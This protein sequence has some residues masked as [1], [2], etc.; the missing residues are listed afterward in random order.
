MRAPYIAVTVAVGCILAACGRGGPA[1]PPP[2]PAVD[3]EERVFSDDNVGIR[4]SVTL[5]IRDRDSL[6]AVWQRVT[7]TRSRP[8][9]VSEVPGLA[10]VDFQRQMLLLVAAGRMV[11]GDQIRV[12]SAGVRRERTGS[13]REENVLV[14]LYTITEGCRRINEP[15]F[16]LEI[17]RVRRH[18]GAVDFRGRRDRA[19]NC[20]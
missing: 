9:P 12:D 1:T 17:V 11:S 2:I 19:T 14:V 18:D 16:P 4:D 6:N 10:S 15:R 7:S 20:R 13:G 5:V 8:T 3:I